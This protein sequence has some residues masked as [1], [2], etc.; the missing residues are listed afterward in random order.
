MK[1]KAKELRDARAQ[2]LRS[3]GPVYSQDYRR[4]TWTRPAECPSTR[5]LLFGLLWLLGAESTLSFG[6]PLFSAVFPFARQPPVILLLHIIHQCSHN[7]R[8]PAYFNL[9]AAI[10]ALLSSLAAANLAAFSSFVNSTLPAPAPP[11][12]GVPAREEGAEETGEKV[13]SAGAIGGENVGC[14]GVA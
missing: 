8:P 4:R 13:G 12:S 5:S 1:G 3:K 11:T 6:R 14:G 9:A 10:L 7:V 2:K